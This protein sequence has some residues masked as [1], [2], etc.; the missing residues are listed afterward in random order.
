MNERATFWLLDQVD[1]PT[2]RQRYVQLNVHGPG[3]ESGVYEETEKINGDF[4]ARWFPRSATGNQ[5]EP[6]LHKVDDYWDFRP[7]DARDSGERD[8]R[9]GR[10]GGFGRGGGSYA[11]AYMSYQTS[12]PEDYRWN[13][14]P[15]AN[16]TLEDFGPLIDLLK[17]LDPEITL[18]VMFHERVEQLVAVDEWTRV[19]AAR[20]VANDWDTYGLRRGKNAYL[21]RAPTG[22]WHLLPWDSDLSWRSRGF[23]RFSRSA[24]LFSDKFPAVERLLRKPE[25]RRMFLGHAAFLATKRLEPKY[26][27]RIADELGKH[28][29]ASGYELEEAAE[30]NREQILAEIPEVEFEVKT[31]ERE[32][33]EGKPDVVRVSGTAPLIT[34]GFRLGSRE[35]TTRF[36]T[37]ESWTAEFDVDSANRELR[38]LRAI[39]RDGDEVARATITIPEIGVRKKG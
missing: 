5:V 30:T 39:D 17:L 12:D 15:R 28:V 6:R 7:P 1:V 27:S 14:P 36:P 21:Y 38:V 2:P 25:Y 33:R 3:Q 24:S 9:R 35:V 20:T 34:H 18:E 16:G 31:V 37:V 32:E 29:G 26:F 8:R 19:L 23:G 11:E 4:L 10:F 22:Q 13:F